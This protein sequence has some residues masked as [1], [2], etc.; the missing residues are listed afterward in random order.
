MI[1]MICDICGK[2]GMNEIFGIV[3]ADGIFITLTDGTI[4]P[5]PENCTHHICSVCLDKLGY[6]KQTNGKNANNNQ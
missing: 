5:Y 2:D 6:K 3:N 4:L 1:K